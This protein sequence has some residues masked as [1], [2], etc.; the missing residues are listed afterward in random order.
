MSIAGLAP[1]DET[2]TIG[3]LTRDPYP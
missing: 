1:L 3:E 2:I